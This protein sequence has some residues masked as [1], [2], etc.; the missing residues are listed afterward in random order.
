M[1]AG[2]SPVSAVKRALG[3]LGIESIA[4]SSPQA[5]RR[6][7]RF[8]ESWQRRVV[9]KDNCVAFGRRRLQIPQAA[10]RYSFAKW[11]VKVYEHLDW[12]LSVGHSPL[13]LG[14]YDA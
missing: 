3:P 9:W 12:T 10:W 4:A 8:W 1:D 14:H 6:M 2:V 11:R 13:T 7:E 5:R